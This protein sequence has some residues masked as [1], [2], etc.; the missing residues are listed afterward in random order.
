MKRVGRKESVILATAFGFSGAAISTWSII[1]SEFTGFI[2]G[3][4]LIGVLNGFANYYRFTAADSVGHG[5]KS[6]AI[7]FV[8]AD[9]VVAAIV[10][11]N[12]AN[13]RKEVIENAYFAGSYAA[14]SVLYVL[15]LSVLRFLKLPPMHTQE[16][17]ERE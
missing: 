1:E 4:C 12:L 3:V 11:P 6:R 5:H 8:L 10:G 17:A 16:L 7:S 13:Y 2:I 15:S 9:G 14:L